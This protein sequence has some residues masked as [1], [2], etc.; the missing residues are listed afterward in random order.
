MPKRLIAFFLTIACSIHADTGGL[1]RHD[2]QCGT[3]TDGCMNEDNWNACRSL[4]EQ[5]CQNIQMM[6]SCPLQFA[7]GD[8]E[9]GRQLRQE[10]E[11][12]HKQ[13]PKACVSLLVYRDAKCQDGPVRS[14]T[15]PTW[16]KPGSPCCK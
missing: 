15:F 12:K 11:Q 2:D 3:P 7:C 5:G 4:V 16:T 9:R 1:R 14:V 10:M 6:E 13:R 8:A